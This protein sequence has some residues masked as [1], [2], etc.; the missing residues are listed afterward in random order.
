MNSE[1]DFSEFAE[2]DGHSRSE[3]GEKPGVIDIFPRLGRLALADNLFKL[4]EGRVVI[5][6]EVENEGLLGAALVYGGELD[7]DV[8]EDLGKRFD[9][10]EIA[11]AKFGVILPPD[12]GLE[13]SPE[14]W[15][16]V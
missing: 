13:S 10:R 16:I 7:S 15:Y 12:S 6:E 14:D 2:R 1:I 11:A 5:A 3:R 9:A 4:V 8:V